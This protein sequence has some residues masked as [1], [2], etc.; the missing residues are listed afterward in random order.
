METTALAHSDGEEDG[1]REDAELREALKQANERQAAMETEMAALKEQEK[2]RYRKLWNLNCAQLIE[3]HEALSAKEVEVKELQEQVRGSV[4]GRSL[5]RYPSPTVSSESYVG[6]AISRG[7]TQR[8]G[9]AP[10]VEM[11]SGEDTENTLND[12]IPS[13]KTSC[14]ME[15]LDQS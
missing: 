3:F 12:W 6:E 11:F 9:R 14:R 5:P 2:V 7:S 10:P 13:L 15:W 8:R 4:P 1:S